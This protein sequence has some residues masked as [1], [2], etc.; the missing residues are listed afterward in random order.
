[1]YFCVNLIT[2]YL[3]CVVLYSYNDMDLSLV[4]LCV[5][6][7]CVLD[8]VFV[9]EILQMLFKSLFYTSRMLS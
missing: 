2:K 4:P 7:V 3:N 6:C 1:M 5:V 9:V 8:L